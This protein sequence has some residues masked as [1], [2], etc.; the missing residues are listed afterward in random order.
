MSRIFGGL[1]SG[2]Y[3]DEAEAV[4]TK[5]QA[6]W[7]MLLVRGGAQGSHFSINGHIDVARAELPDVLRDLASRIEAGKI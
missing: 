6:Q 3:G 2:D 7:V 1:E 4:L 5:T